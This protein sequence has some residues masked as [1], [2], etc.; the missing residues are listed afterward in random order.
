[1]MPSGDPHYDV[2]YGLVPH[3]IAGFSPAVCST[4]AMMSSEVEATQ[5]IVKGM[6]DLN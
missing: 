3:K 5:P 2:A 6:F 1:M 4:A